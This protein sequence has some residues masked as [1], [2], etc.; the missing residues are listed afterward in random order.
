MDIG[1]IYDELSVALVQQIADSVAE[2]YGWLTESD[3]TI[4]SDD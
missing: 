1:H 2:L 3:P 4:Q